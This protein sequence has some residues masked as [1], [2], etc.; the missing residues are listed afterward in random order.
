MYSTLDTL[1]HM[2]VRFCGGSVYRGWWHQGRQ[3]GYG[4]MVQMDQKT[5]KKLSYYGAWVNG[6]RQGYGIGDNEEL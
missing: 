3:H 2:F 6:H 1:V 4:E 5:L